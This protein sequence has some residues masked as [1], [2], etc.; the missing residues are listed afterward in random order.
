VRILR[1]SVSRLPPP[2]SDNHIVAIQHGGSSDLANLALSCLHCNR[3]KGPNIAGRD[4]ATEDIQRLFHPRKDSWDEHFQLNGAIL[5]GL[6]VIGRVTVQVL[7]MNEPEF[8]AAREA[9]LKEGVYM[10]RRPGGI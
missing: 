1:Y 5:V 7:A 6:T 3:H 4:P 10:A 9:L 8:L 2:V